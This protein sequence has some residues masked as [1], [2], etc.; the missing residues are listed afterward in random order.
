[1]DWNG[2]GKHDWQDD[3]IFHNVIETDNNTSSNTSSGR[4][5]SYSSGGS[6]FHVSQLGKVVIVLDLILCVA[7]LFMGYANIIGD[8]LGFG[9][10]GFLIA[11]CLD[12]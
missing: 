3:A 4:G 5:G 6:S 12:S 7:A 8:L 10:V 9:V 2:D 1:M 11:Q